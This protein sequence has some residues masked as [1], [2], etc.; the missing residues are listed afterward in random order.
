M[1]QHKNVE[2]FRGVTAVHK[3][4]ADVLSDAK[5]LKTV[6]VIGYDEN[7]EE[8]FDRSNPNRRENCWLID[9]YK[10]YELGALSVVMNE[11]DGRKRWSE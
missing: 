1:Q 7:G 5:K 2:N 3:P 8:Y 11:S 9:R 6:I 10:L 4:V